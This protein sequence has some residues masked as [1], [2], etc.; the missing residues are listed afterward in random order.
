MKD[1]MEQPGQIIVNQLVDEVLLKMAP[2]T[3]DNHV[4]CLDVVDVLENVVLDW[5][6]GRLPCQVSSQTR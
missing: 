3:I 5:I 2:K 6:N 4:H 1:G